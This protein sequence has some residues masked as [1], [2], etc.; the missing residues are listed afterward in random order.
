MNMISNFRW[1]SVLA[2]IGTVSVSWML[3]PWLC[4]FLF[5]FDPCD[6]SV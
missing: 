3:C 2:C 6:S 5:E 1:L 4:A